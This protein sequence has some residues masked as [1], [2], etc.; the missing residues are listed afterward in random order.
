MKQAQLI[1]SK[2][3][4]LT[5]ALKNE[6]ANHSNMLFWGFRAQQDRLASTPLTHPETGVPC[7]IRVLVAKRP[8]E[9][10]ENSTLL[11]GVTVLSGP[12]DEKTMH[13]ETDPH[14]IY[15][16]DYRNSSQLMD[17]LERFVAAFQECF[18]YESEQDAEDEAD[19]ALRHWMEDSSFTPP[20][21]K[22]I[23]MTMAAPWFL[24]T[25]VQPALNAQ[26]SI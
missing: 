13:E 25:D 5:E 20:L 4:G 2:F 26:E 11:I 7:A 1:P 15:C 18:I 8:A 3:Y 10:G 16:G 17:G 21:F 14:V 9:K 24:G 6:D 22:S 23:G 19:L 12:L